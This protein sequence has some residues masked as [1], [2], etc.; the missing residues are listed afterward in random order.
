MLYF[1]R[2]IKK[3]ENN[4][5]LLLVEILIT[6][7]YILLFFHIGW[8][9]AIIEYALFI[10]GLVVAS[11]IDVKHL[12]LPDSLTLSG[13]VIGLLGAALNPE[14][15]REFLPALFGVLMGGGFLWLV[16]IFYYVFRK[17]EGLGGGDIK[18]IAWIGSILTWKAIPFVILMSCLAGLFSA[19]LSFVYHR[20]GLDYGI[21]FGPF[22]SFAALIYLFYGQKVGDLYLSLFLPY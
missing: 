11:A 10:F 3:G 15:H 13:I 12:I 19:L 22:L 4:V 14:I 9:F 5:R 8:K 7:L 6:V 20:K 16:A 2:N 21:P 18:L 17:E 1:I